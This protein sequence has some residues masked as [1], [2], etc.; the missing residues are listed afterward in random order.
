MSRKTQ[1]YTPNFPEMQRVFTGRKNI[2]AKE[3]IKRK[4]DKIRAH[5][6]WEF[7]QLFLN[8]IPGRLLD[9]VKYLDNSRNRIYSPEIIFWAFLN[10]I[11][12]QGTSCSETVRKVQS[13]MQ[14]KGRKQ[15]SSNTSA[16]C[17]AR[18][19]LPL[20]LLKKPMGPALAC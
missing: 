18:K 3:Q 12:M 1:K 20:K 19:R 4:I 2:S 7:R 8:W 9:G 15:P 17:Q 5:Q 13:W 6:L 10:Q 11:F 14:F 16:Y